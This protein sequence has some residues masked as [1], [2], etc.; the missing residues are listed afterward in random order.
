M[1]GPSPSALTE[2]VKEPF[3]PYW[4]TAALTKA[5]AGTTVKNPLVLKCLILGS[6]GVYTGYVHV[7]APSEEYYASDRSISD[8]YASAY[9]RLASPVAD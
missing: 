7:H 3:G 8:T 1:A 5:V 4:E 6:G 9:S 2:L